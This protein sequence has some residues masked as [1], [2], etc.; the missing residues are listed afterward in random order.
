MMM[1]FADKK[2]KS[3][4]EILTEYANGERDF[5]N[6]VCKGANFRGVRLRGADFSNSDLS[7]SDFGNADL[8]ECK[9]I[10]SKLEWCDFSFATLREADFTNASLCYS[11]FNQT[12]VEKAN[13]DNTDVNNC[14]ALNTIWHSAKIENM[15]NRSGMATSLSE[16]TES[17]REE[18]RRVLESLRTQIPLSVWLELKASVERKQ[19][20][21]QTFE[22]TKTSELTYTPSITQQ[23]QPSESSF[24]GFETVYSRGKKREE[25]LYQI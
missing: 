4:T 25:G 14:L 8:S 16:I 13:F 5:R 7:F 24:Y 23:I 20:T 15:K 1:D 22:E 17:S 10:N 18:L 11:F 6:I 19:A 9:F 12:I 2:F 21:K 3:V